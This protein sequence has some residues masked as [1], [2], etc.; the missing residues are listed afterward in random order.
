MG[1]FL[2]SLQNR[3]VFLIYILG[4]TI[5]PILGQGVPVWQFTVKTTV[6][7]VPFIT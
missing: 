1:G 6:L 7:T 5:I 4:Q 3:I 2:V